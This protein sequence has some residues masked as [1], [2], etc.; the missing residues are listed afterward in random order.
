MVFR[1]CSC[2]IH[3]EFCKGLCSITLLFQSLFQR[4]LPYSGELNDLM[5]NT[6]FTSR[7]ILWGSLC[8]LCAYIDISFHIP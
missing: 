5:C 2:F 4:Q 3:A 6:E 8:L 1:S 7:E